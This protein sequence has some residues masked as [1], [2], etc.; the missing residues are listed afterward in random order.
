MKFDSVI[1][2]F[3]FWF[4]RYTVNNRNLLHLTVKP[5]VLSLLMAALLIVEPFVTS[6]GSIENPL[7]VPA[8]R[9]CQMTN[10]VPE[11]EA[12]TVANIGNYCFFDIQWLRVKILVS[13]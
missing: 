12:T 4:L 10:E 7:P 2:N 9:C 11:A 3:F 6:G 1:F 5:P 8:I 13:R